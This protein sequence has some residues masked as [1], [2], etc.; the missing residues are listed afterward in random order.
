MA[1]S[2]PDTLRRQ[3]TAKLRRRLSPYVFISDLDRDSR[4][5]TL[6][7]EIQE[8]I[9]DHSDKHQSEIRFIPLDNVATVSWRPAKGGVAFSGLNVIDF[10]KRARSK[11]MSVTERAQ[12]ALLPSLYKQIVRIPDVDLN[13]RPLKRI[14]VGVT[15]RGYYSPSDFKRSQLERQK[16]MNYFHL[17]EG[18][19]YIKREEGLYVPG[20]DMKR[21][22][23]DVVPSTQLYEY[24]M[25]E[26]L[27]KRTEYIREVLH[28]T[29]IVPYLRWC[30]AYYL[31]AYKAGHLMQADQEELAAYY[32][33][34]YGRLHDVTA[35]E[36]QLES[37]VNVKILSLKQ[38]RFY[39]GK[40]AI[41]NEF[42]ANVK[43]DPSLFEA[44]RHN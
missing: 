24:I 8:N 43:Q 40:Q 16:V 18:M 14:L 28:W 26:V 36:P 30:N 7:I 15:R 38:N 9:I 1:M 17:L 23:A 19:N 41:L 29:M 39:E 34:Y 3:L 42:A 4:T 27:R 10:A 2:E 33:Q 44:L 22:P 25:G 32:T 21:L 37:I 5:A 13:M 12:Q 35:E 11:Y 20:A 6:G 31:P